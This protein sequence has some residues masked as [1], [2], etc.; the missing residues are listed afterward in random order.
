VGDCVVY[1]VDKCVPVPCAT[2]CQRRICCKIV[3]QFNFSQRR[4]DIAPGLHLLELRRPEMQ[5]L[6]LQ[7]RL[8][9]CGVSHPLVVT[10]GD[11]DV[12]TAVR[13]MK[14]GAA[15]VLEKS[16]SDEDILKAIESAIKQQRPEGCGEGEAR[17]RRSHAAY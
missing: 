12:P 6:E 5:G 14:A 1:V 2:S 7:E 17:C 8:V 9:A 13:A 4:V 11:G 16:R 15:D 10:T 3:R